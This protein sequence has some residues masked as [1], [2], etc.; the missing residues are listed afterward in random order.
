VFGYGSLIWKVDFAYERRVVGYVTGV[1]RRFWQGSHDHRGTPTSPG[2][3]VTLVD[4]T[5]YLREFAARDDTRSEHDHEQAERCWGVAY[6]IGRADVEEVIAHLDHREK[7]G[8]SSLRTT[9]FN[10]IDKPFATATV[11]I[12][13][14]DNAAFVGPA[15]LP[16]I[17]KTIVHNVGPS[18]RNIDY[19]INL[20][21]AVRVISANH[22]DHHLLALEASVRRIA[23][24]EGV[25]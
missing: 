18:G 22:P 17:A 16:S 10:A 20:C 11:Y 25:D 7:N 8:Y 9:V 13:T 14:T 5:E 3:V 2:R 12:G 23:G 4:G 21:H 15:P 1:R 19:F 6:L 24:A